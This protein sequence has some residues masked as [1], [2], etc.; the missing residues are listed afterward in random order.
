MRVVL[1]SIEPDLINVEVA[2]VPKFGVRTDCSP[3][4]SLAA[5][6]GLHPHCHSFLPTVA[7]LLPFFA[8]RF[9][10]KVRL[11]SACPLRPR[12][13]AVLL[14]QRVPVLPLSTLFTRFLDLDVVGVDA[15]LRDSP[16]GYATYIIPAYIGLA[17]LV[18]LAPLM[19]VCLCCPSSCCLRP[20][21]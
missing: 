6:L 21:L 16:L 10:G 14:S 9:T 1:L 19:L 13:P 3:P 11:L 12:F 15:Y 5:A 18:L 17:F 2:A 8:F 7:A 20:K 4:S